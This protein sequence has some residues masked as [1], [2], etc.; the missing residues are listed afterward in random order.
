MT[1][2][3]FTDADREFVA[4]HVE[5]YLPDRIFDAHAHLFCHAHYPP[6]KLPAHLSDTPSEIGLRSKQ[7]RWLASSRWGR[8]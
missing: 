6:D 8:C 3:T 4:R 7:D 5:P 1:A 2:W